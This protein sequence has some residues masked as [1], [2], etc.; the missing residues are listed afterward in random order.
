MVEDLPFLLN[1]LEDEL[2]GYEDVRLSLVSPAKTQR[3]PD[4]PQ[5]YDPTSANLHLQS[6]VLVRAGKKE[7]FFPIEWYRE[8][9][10]A[11][12]RKA[13]VELMAF[14]GRLE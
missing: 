1:L 3:S 12:L 5:D 11:S 7:F 6:G 8:K 2:Q 10:R 13:T 14:L 9:T 4:L